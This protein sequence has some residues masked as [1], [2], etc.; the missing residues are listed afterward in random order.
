MIAWAAALLLAVVLAGIEFRRMDRRH[1]LARSG[2]AAL[3]VAALALLLEPPRLPSRSADPGVVVLETP[4]T[5]ATLLRAVADSL[6]GTPIA[7][8]PD[9]VADLDALRRRH[10]DAHTLV[11]VGWGLRDAW[12]EGHADLIVRQVPAPPPAGV[13]H[14]RWPQALSLGTTGVISGTLAGRSA[15]AV[16]SLRGP[17]GSL[18]SART[19]P[20]R[21]SSFRFPISPP[22]VGRAEY[23]LSAPGVADETVRVAVEPPN[24]PALLVLEDA[25]SFETTFLRR[26]LVPQGATMAI[27][28][29]LSLDRDREER[30]NFGNQPLR[31]LTAGLLAQFDAV[32]IDGRSLVGLS[33]TERTVLGSAIQDAGLGL[34]ILPDSIPRELTPFFPF[35]LEPTGDANERL[36]RPLWSE[37]T[38]RSTIAIPAAPAEI[39]LRPGQQALIR[40]PVG[41]VL[42]A[43]APAGAG[44]IATSLLLA[45]S[46]WQLEAESRLFGGYWSLLLGATARGRGERWALAADGPMVEQL[47]ISL[48]LSTDDP[49]PLAVV[50]GPD[51]APDTL[52]LAQDLAD[53]GRWWGRFWPRQTGW[54][55]VTNRAG[56][57]YQFDVGVARESAREAVARLQATARRVELSPA[58]PL[59][60]A[61]P[62]YRRLAPLVPFLVLVAALAALWAE[63]RG[64]WPQPREPL[65]GPT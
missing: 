47:P 62:R 43:M 28:T 17:G 26:W 3:S 65:S 40:D 34:L 16:V 14:L 19:V 64:L 45:P 30:L 54:H 38:D 18:D 21:T 12:W 35:T 37:L 50:V 41:R 48:V 61:G 22:A 31:P 13:T 53:P 59:V 4:G 24:P 44:R 56:A 33:A 57:T 7:R 52:G 8:W 5:D 51:G 36:V 42:A 63:G 11:V 9:S 2:L 1:R 20:D 49:A 60:A 27:R 55:G 10:P 46:R 58:A 32:M 15:P 6:P 25:P 23:V 29:R 39:R